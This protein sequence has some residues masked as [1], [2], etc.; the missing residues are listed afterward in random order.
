[1]ALN[2]SLQLQSGT[3]A[4][5]ISPLVAEY[6]SVHTV[7]VFAEEQLARYL[8]SKLYWTWPEGTTSLPLPLPQKQA[9]C[10]SNAW[11]SASSC[12]TAD[13]EQVQVLGLILQHW[14]PE[15]HDTIPNVAA[16]AVGHDTTH[17]AADT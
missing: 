6:V 11:G 15:R 3:A 12:I 14:L 10:L 2:I 13:C 16:D 1:M 9:A 17:D 4:T 7:R 5:H 8:S